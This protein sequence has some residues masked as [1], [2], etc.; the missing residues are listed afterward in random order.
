MHLGFAGVLCLMRN[1]VFSWGWYSF[2]VV[3]EELLGEALV[4]IAPIRGISGEVKMFM[5]GSVPLD[6]PGFDSVSGRLPESEVCA[7]CFFEGE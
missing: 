6:T 1:H 5:W 3:V 2:E 7:P 4:F